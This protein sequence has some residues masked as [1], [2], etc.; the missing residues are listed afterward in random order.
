MNLSNIC[1]KLT[2]PLIYF[3]P[4]AAS[5]TETRPSTMSLTVARISLKSWN[6]VKGTFSLSQYATR[7]VT[8]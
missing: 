5:F 4:V 7:S 3:L 1:K 8:Q 2:S 6:V